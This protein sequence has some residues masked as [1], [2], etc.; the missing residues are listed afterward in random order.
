MREVDLLIVGGGSA[1][2]S[3]ALGAYE[4]GLRNILLVE[5]N[6]R[7]GGILNQCIHNGFGLIHF[8]EELTGPEFAD[9][10]IAEVQKL[11]IECSLNSMCTKITAEKVATV[12]SP[13]GVEDIKCKA[14][15]LSSGCFERPAGA[16]M[17]PGKRLSGVMNAGEA[18]L[19]LNQEGFLPG[20]NVF[21][22]G[23]GDIGLI[24]A[25]RFT[26]EGAKVHGVAEICPYSNGL[27]RN[28]VQC[29]NDFDIPL[30]LSHTIVDVDGHNGKLEKVT[31]AQVDEKRKPIAGT[32]KEFAVDLLCLSIG[33]IPNNALLKDSG[34]KVSKTRGSAVDES[35]MTAIEGVFSCGNALHVHDLVDFVV[36]EGKE[37]GLKAANYVLN[38]E[39]EGERS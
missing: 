9:R 29:L 34:A 35:L 23:S 31:I 3:A 18:Q 2:L 17:L 15:V 22:L 21:I 6:D 33:L 10:M 4:G 8:K 39:K 12:S 19:L 26:L 13:S 36:E 20:K 37:A 16:I 27:N 7:L 25:R 30:F 1:G 38:G 28:I 24:M 32:E 5:R 14:I 11:G